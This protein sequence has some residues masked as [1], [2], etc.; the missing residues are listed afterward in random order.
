MNQ[1]NRRF[2]S[3]FNSLNWEMLLLQSRWQA[4]QNQQ[5]RLSLLDQFRQKGVTR[6]EYIGFQPVSRTF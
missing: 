5:T 1:T 3:Q 2:Q 6:S 4:L